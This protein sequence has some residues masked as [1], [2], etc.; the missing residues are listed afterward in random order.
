MGH[1]SFRIVSVSGKAVNHD[2]VYHGSMPS[3]AARKAFKRLCADRKK[4]HLSFEICEITRGGSGKS[5]MY[6]GSRKKLK[7][8]LII[9]RDGVTIAIKYEST[10]TRK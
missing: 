6:E 7:C 10:V 8:P 9:E 2:G 4:C 5:Y 1:R 3:A